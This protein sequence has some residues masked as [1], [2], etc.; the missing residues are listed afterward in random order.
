M[1]FYSPSF[2]K[3]QR[4]EKVASQ[5]DMAPTLLGLLNFSY[6]T[7]FFGTDLLNEPMASRAFI[8]N[9]QKVA[10]VRDNKLTILAPKR[11]VK[12]YSWPEINESDEDEKATKDAISY[13]Q[14][15]SWWKEEYKRI[16]SVVKKD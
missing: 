14:A 16:P 15:A 13:Y 5:I 8:S 12:Q 9:Y 1:I 11:Q 3:P 7:K 4:Y 10:M 2:I 6:Y